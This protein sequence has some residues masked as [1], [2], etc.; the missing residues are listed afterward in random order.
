[1]K[2][3]YLDTE[4]TGLNPLIDEVVEIAI[5]DDQG[6]TL[7]HTLVC[8]RHVNAW[9]SAQA[10]HGI[11]PRDVADAPRLDDVL[12]AIVS[13]VEGRQLVIY[14]ATFDMDFLPPAV[15]HAAG[16]VLCCMEAFADMYG[17][18]RDDHEGSRWQSLTTAADYV[19][20]HWQ[21]AAHRALSDAL[22]CRAVWRYVKGS[23]MYRAA[24]DARRAHKAKQHQAAAL[25]AQYEREH[26]HLVMQRWLS[27]QNCADRVIRRFFL[28]QTGQRHWLSGIPPKQQRR[29][30]AAV[31]MGLP[32][33]LPDECYSPGVEIQAIYRHQRDIPEHLAARNWFP[34][35]KWVR[36]LLVPTA[37]FV[38][39][40]SA[41]ALYDKRQLE[42]IKTTHWRR[43]APLPT[44]WRTRTMLR[45]E[46]VPESVI[47]SLSPVAE[48]YNE[49][50]GFWY[51][52]F[53]RSNIE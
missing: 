9:P 35:L 34:S 18:R 37:A 49:M 42:Q 16:A 27:A 45:Q 41:R 21:D 40:R 29:Q 24:V 7:V 46:G 1:M 33:N 32:D 11:S 13:A 17:D 26:E 39:P 31:F 3:V 44:H 50:R 15:A 4:T 12:P 48:R 19:D 47:A 10:V 36:D 28:R 22:A 25:L 30:L 6:A 2:V 38:G 20:H 43:F 52:I 23:E 53:D 8:P 51:P 14:N 5:V